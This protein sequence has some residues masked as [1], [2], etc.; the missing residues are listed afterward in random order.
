MD[1]YKLCGEI[2]KLSPKI[3]YAGV[4]NTHSGEVYEKTQKEIGR[5]FDK[6]QT[7]KSMMQAYMR[8]K[9]RQAFIET[10]GEPI[11]TMTKY[12]KINRITLTCGPNSLL[13]VTTEPDLEPYEIA[14]SVLK[15]R[16][17]FADKEESTPTLRHQL[18]F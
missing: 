10:S 1:C 8:W 14:D 7:K 11:Y 2:L 6:E 9:T 4:Y 3:R 18:N 17:K 12:Q 13:M 5:L 15:L 16:E